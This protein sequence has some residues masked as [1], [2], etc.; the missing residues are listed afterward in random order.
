LRKPRYSLMSPQLSI[1]TLPVFPCCPPVRLLPLIYLG[2]STLMVRNDLIPL[3]RQLLAAKKTVHNQVA[4]GM[5]APVY[6]W[7]ALLSLKRTGKVAEGSQG[8]KTGRSLF[9]FWFSTPIGMRR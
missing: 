5:H 6:T 7:A 1:Q 3:V 8:G 4:T 9:R 2:L